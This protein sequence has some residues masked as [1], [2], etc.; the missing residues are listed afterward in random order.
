M[1]LSDAA[2]L[3][4]LRTRTHR[5]LIGMVVLVGAAVVALPALLDVPPRPTGSEMAIDMPTRAAPPLTPMVGAGAA[6]AVG[7]SSA[8]TAAAVAVAPVL[9]PVS[10]ARVAAG[11]SSAVVTTQVAQVDDTQ[12]LQRER[13][14]Q[15]GQVRERAERERAQRERERLERQKSEKEKASREKAARDK[16]ER[17]KAERDR[18]EREKAE[19]DKAARAREAASSRHWVQVGAYAEPATVRGVR[20]KIDKLGLKSVEQPVDTAAGP[21]TR[22]RLG[23]FSSREEAER[24]MARLKAGGLGATV[25]SP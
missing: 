12:R 7:A 14:A 25:I 6:P 22:V 4:Q 21:R 9:P 1:P 24:A 5:R 17:E 11:A 15:D 3:E 13:A 18:V 19:R 8:A 2:E 10:T 16:A 23:P 20:Q